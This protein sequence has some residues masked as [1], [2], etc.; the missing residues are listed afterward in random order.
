MSG[1]VKSHRV[2]LV[3]R[4]ARASRELNPHLPRTLWFYEAGVVVNAFGRGMT[5]PFVLIYLHNVRGLGLGL[6]G[7]IAA[8]YAAAS[9]AGSL[10]G[11]SLAD[12]LGARLVLIGALTTAGGGYGWFAFVHHP[13]AAFVAI[14]IAGFGNGAFLPAQSATIAALAGQARRH[15]AYAVQRAADNL[16]IGLGAAVGGAIAVTSDPTTFTW[17]F[18]L[19]GATSLVFAL[20][21]V[22]LPLADA[23]HRARREPGPGYREV[24][25]QRPVLAVVGLNTLYVLGGYTL[26]ETALPVFA[27]NTAGVGEHGIGLVFLANTIAV[28]CLQLPISRLLEGRRRLPALGAM[29]LGWA[30]IWAAVLFTGV[31]LHGTAALSVFL[32]AVV[33]F[34]GGEC[35]LALVST[36]VADLAPERLRARCLSLIPCS[37]AAGLT[38]GPVVAGFTMQASAYAVWPVGIGLLVAAAAGGIAL[39]RRLPLSVRVTPARERS[40]GPVELEPAAVG[41]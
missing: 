14:A 30:G 38:A 7:V 31:W 20:L 10:A 40:A 25:R 39:E 5:L 24:L 1:I 13:L 32:A 2:P 33:A 9:F 11:G 16:G 19:D 23:G 18:V 4:V 35:V 12:R 29:C 3:A 15:G 27:K 6:S 21:L 17:L 36:L 37:Y 26:L 22:A 8:S 41:A 28:V 34:A